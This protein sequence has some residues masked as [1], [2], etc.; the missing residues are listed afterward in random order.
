MNYWRE[1]VRKKAI[2]STSKRQ[3]AE[4]SSLISYL[5][6]KWLIFMKTASSFTVDQTECSGFNKF[7]PF[8]RGNI[9]VPEASCKDDLLFGRLVKIYLSA[10]PDLEIWE[11]SVPSSMIDFPFDL[12]MKNLDISAVLNNCRFFD[13]ALF[14]FMQIRIVEAYHICILFWKYL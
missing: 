1:I 11:D 8:E 5:L 12:K 13:W 10:Q 9:N 7:A 4:T 2:K 3:W 14:P 6:A